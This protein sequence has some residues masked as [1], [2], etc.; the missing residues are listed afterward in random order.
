M[1]R[2]WLAGA[3]GT[4]ALLSACG[5]GNQESAPSETASATDTAAAPASDAAP[6]ATDSAPPSATPSATEAAATPS[7]TPS[8]SKSAAPAMADAAAAAAP[9]EAFKQCQVCHSA[10]PGKNGIG[11]SL[12]GI[13][14]TKAAEVPGYDFS[15]A[16]K[17]SGLTW[18]EATL[19]KFL[20]S[21]QTVVPGTKM[22]F[23]GLKDADKR[24]AVIAY[25]KSL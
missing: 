16:M 22:T 18:N 10:T 17:G 12:A 24:K 7:P 3:L 5:G 19:D 21:P 4:A 2:I 8:A 25:L 1:N 6:A 15:D 20:T 23:G 11:P 13:Y 14:G 9:P